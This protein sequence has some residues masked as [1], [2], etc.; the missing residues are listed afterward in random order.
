MGNSSLTSLSVR[1]FWLTLPCT[2]DLG[3]GDVLP[4]SVPEVQLVSRTLRPQRKL[5]SEK[6]SPHAREP[7]RTGRP[8]VALGPC[9][10]RALDRAQREAGL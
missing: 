2:G 1:P 5:E 6:S 8:P 3:R 4:P 9:W 7:G 10:R